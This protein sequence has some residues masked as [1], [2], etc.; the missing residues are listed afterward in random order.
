MRIDPWK[1]G[2]V[3]LCAIMALDFAT[4]AEAEP[5]NGPRTG[6][7]VKWGGEMV[8]AVAYAATQRAL[9]PTPTPPPTADHSLPLPAWMP[10]GVLTHEAT[11]HQVAAETGLDP[12][13]LAILVAIECVTGDPYCTSPDGARGLGQV[14]PGTAADIEAATGYPCTAQPYDPLTSLQCGGWYFVQAMRAA[15]ALWSPDL[16]RYAI[17]A[18]GIGYN[19]GPGNIP[20]VV[21]H[22]RAGG[23]PCTT[24]HPDS[25]S[26]QNWE[27]PLSWC[28]QALDMWA[29]AGRQ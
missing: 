22:V 25:F 23:D 7:G 21:R 2:I 27:Q 13:A 3:G 15:G 10:A 1:L 18:A 16:E 11:I 28:R 6:Q 19:S 12:L 5:V 26:A 8:E 29:R 14:M 9:A 24:P 4:T 17:G 20:H